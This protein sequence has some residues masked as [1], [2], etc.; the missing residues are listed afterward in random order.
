MT[1][2]RF[3]ISLFSGIAGLDSGLHKAGFYPLFCAEIDT[4]AQAT[5]KR[6]L[7]EQG[8]KSVVADNMTQIDPHNLRRE[9]GLSKGE[10][11]L[12]C[13]GP[14]CQSFSLIGK[15]GSLVD[16]RGL[17]L[18]QMVRYAQAFM[19]KV[20][21]LEQVKGLKSAPCLN[22]IKGGVLKNLVYSFQELGY[23]VSYEV[24]RAADFGVPQ[25]RD[26]LFLVAS[27]E[28][29]FSFPQATHFPATVTSLPST[30]F[31][32]LFNIYKT[33]YDAIGDLPEPVLKGQTEKIPNHVD[34]TPDR[35]RER[36]NG[37]PE[38]ECLARQLHLPPEQRQQLNPK[39]DTTKF[40]RL[41]WHEPSLTLRGGEVF[42]HPDENRYLTPRECLRLHSF[43]DAHI[44]IGPIRGR[45][46]NVKT[47]DQHRFVAN[48]V[49]P[50]LAEVLGKSIV[51]QFFSN[52]NRRLIA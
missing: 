52:A 5:L 33:V 8:I 1:K 3:S 31:D 47:L 14:P 40:R 44:L 19:P 10:L 4:N 51:S 28:G 49:P 42:Y 30:F 27:K 32:K 50:I 13:G 22:N 26:R 16:E 17:L 20:V 37:V 21:L 12:L 43:S 34:V 6:W 45:S 29:K 24:L 15:R 35:D 38:G 41:A 7:S 23:T 9:L 46:G 36:I 48:A 39:K 25:I 11:D 2:K 18:F